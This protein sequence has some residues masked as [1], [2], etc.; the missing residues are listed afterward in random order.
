VDAPA[1]VEGYQKLAEIAREAPEQNLTPEQ[2]EA[3]IHGN[4]PF[5]SLPKFLRRHRVEIVIALL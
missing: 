1:T 2:I 4:T 3:K 5:V